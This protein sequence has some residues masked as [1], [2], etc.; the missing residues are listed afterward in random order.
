M[1][2]FGAAVLYGMVGAWVGLS[3]GVG[4]I[5]RNRNRDYW[6]WFVL[7]IVL[8]PLVTVA[9]LHILRPLTGTTAKVVELQLAPDWQP[10]P[11]VAPAQPIHVA[12]AVKAAAKPEAATASVEKLV[13]N[14][15]GNLVCP[16]CNNTIRAD[17][18]A[19]PDCGHDL[20]KGRH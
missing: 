14:G 10:E 2:S 18:V 9:L 19:C 5:A 20:P 11:E 16:Y 12:P 1:S 3:A 15:R 4:S 17:V 7:S 6:A 13:R 8:S